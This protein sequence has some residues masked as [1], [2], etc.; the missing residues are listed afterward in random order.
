MGVFDGE[1][2]SPRRLTGQEAFKGTPHRAGEHNVAPSC[3]GLL[4]SCWQ[5]CLG[6]AVGPKTSTC[7]P[8]AGGPWVP[9]PGG[10]GLGKVVVQGL[11]VPPTTQGVSVPLGMSVTGHLPYS[12][13]RRCPWCCEKAASARSGVGDQLWALS[14]KWST[15]PAVGERCKSPVH[16]GS[17]AWTHTGAFHRFLE[18]PQSGE[19]GTVMHKFPPP[20]ASAAPPAHPGP[21]AAP[22]QDHRSSA[23]PTSHPSTL[24]HGGGWVSGSSL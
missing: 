22:R 10:D 5:A 6:R 12:L 18:M 24:S 20:A 13:W 3:S 7:S 23:P 19:S 16:T 21:Y 8:A 15:G 11:F 4:P 17:G 1:K 14:W 2:S 9:G